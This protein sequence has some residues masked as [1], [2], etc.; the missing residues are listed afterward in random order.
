M[1]AQ[2]AAFVVVPQAEGDQEPRVER[3][4]HEERL[5]LMQ[6]SQEVLCAF[7]RD[8]TCMRVLTYAP[9]SDLIRVWNPAP[10]RESLCDA[11]G[12]P[13]QTD[14]YGQETTRHQS[15]LL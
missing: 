2:G 4:G 9:D 12:K 14:G 10:D 3:L 1:H 11:T 7:V 13:A 15:A 5:E 8:V 6:L